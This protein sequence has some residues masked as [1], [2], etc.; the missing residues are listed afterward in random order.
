MSL[1]LIWTSDAANTLRSVA[2]NEP[3][4]GLILGVG[5]FEM[6]EGLEESLIKALKQ[7]NK[8]REGARASVLREFGGSM[9]EETIEVHPVQ[10]HTRS[11]KRPV[12][13][14]VVTMR[15]YEAYCSVFSPQP[16]LV[17]GWCRG[18]FSAT[19]LIA[20]LYAHTFPEKEWS[21][22]FDEAIRGMEGF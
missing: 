17:E 22:R 7:A 18:G 10:V 21:A 2:P 8:A 19:E 16:A 14:K 11:D 5:G 13:P 15:A 6:P 4:V 20:F 12:C 3:V 9:P 1:R